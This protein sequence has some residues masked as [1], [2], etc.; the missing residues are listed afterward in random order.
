[1]YNSTPPGGGQITPC[2]DPKLLAKM[3][4]YLVAV[5]GG[6]SGKSEKVKTISINP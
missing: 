5:G 4:L 3:E 6:G 1:M 2:T